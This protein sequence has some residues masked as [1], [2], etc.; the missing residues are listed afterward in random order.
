MLIMKNA[1]PPTQKM[2]SN[3]SFNRTALFRKFVNKFRLSLLKDAIVM[4][5]VF[6]LLRP[7]T[8]ELFEIIEIRLQESRMLARFAV[9]VYFAIDIKSTCRLSHK[10]FKPTLHSIWW[11]SID[12]SH[13][14]KS[15]GNFVGQHML[16]THIGPKTNGIITKFT[17]YHSENRTVARNWGHRYNNKTFTI[18]YLQFNSS[19][20]GRP[21]R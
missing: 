8:G 4:R 21:T 16:E 15:I 9:N 1:L 12:V 7:A 19:C 17:N 20:S 5:N 3:Q 2:S 11:Y 14:W 18:W 13:T 10:T 6:F